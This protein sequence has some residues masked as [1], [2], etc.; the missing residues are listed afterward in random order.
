MSDETMRA[1]CLD[2]TIGFMQ[3]LSMLRDH[4]PN[5]DATPDMCKHDDENDSISD[6][7]SDIDRVDDSVC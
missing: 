6:I 5:A 1:S 2:W 3:E 7:D 4:A